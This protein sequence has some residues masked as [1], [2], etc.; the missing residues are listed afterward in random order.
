[1]FVVV[2]LVIAFTNGGGYVLLI[3]QVAEPA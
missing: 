1:M 2:N 3:W